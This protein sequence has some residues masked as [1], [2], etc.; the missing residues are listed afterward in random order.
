MF[1][2]IRVLI[3]I[4]NNNIYINEWQTAEFS[5]FRFSN[6][7]RIFHSDNVPAGQSNEFGHSRSVW[8]NG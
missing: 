2:I 4:D 3:G 6:D 8:L 5:G 1:R 7:V